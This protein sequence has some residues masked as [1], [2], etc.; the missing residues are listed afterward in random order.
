MGRREGGRVVEGIGSEERKGG[1]EG[2]ERD[3]VR[4]EK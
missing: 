1:E 4:K 2:V 3:E